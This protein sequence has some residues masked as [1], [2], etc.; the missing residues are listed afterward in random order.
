MEA[1]IANGFDRT[2]IDDIAKRAGA[3]K[4]TVYVYFKTKE[5]LFEAALRARIG[6]VYAQLRGGF[7]SQLRDDPDV[8]ATELLRRVISVVYAQIV[9][10]PDRRA[11]L[12]IMIAEGE[13]FPQLSQYYYDE[14]LSGV[15]D[16]MPSIVRR[17]VERGEFRATPVA[18]HA[19]VIM[20]PSIMAAVWKM[21]FDHAAPLDLERH[22]E[23]HLDLVLNGLLKRPE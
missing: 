14:L 4:G 12:R 21:T 3:A 7:E 16:V 13:R 1:F 8:S 23:A 22:A 5:E 19:E 18:D 6:P 17:G 20:G 2:T 15:R 11:L 10:D 9:A